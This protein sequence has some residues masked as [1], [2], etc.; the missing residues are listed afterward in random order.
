MACRFTVNG[1]RIVATAAK[2]EAALRNVKP[3]PVRVHAVEIGGKLY[4]VAQALAVAF[5]LDRARCYGN[6]ASRV[7]RELGFKVSATARRP[8]PWGTVA[9]LRQALPHRTREIGPEE[10]EA[11]ELPPI[12][13]E[14]SRWERW[15]DIAEYGL[16]FL[17]LPRGKPGVYEARL[18]GSEERLTIGRASNLRHRILN[19]LIRGHASHPAGGKIRDQEDVH[20][21]LIRWAVTDRP[22][23]AEEELHRRHL[24]RF[25]H[26]PKYTLRT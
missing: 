5:G 20:Q 18:Q 8:K 24:A 9:G 3:D 14:W 13:L 19:G 4:P 6:V 11:L 7:F 12:L 26:L 16:A 10:E 15:D 25:G 23:A 17:D 2:V 1:R 21:V 22:A